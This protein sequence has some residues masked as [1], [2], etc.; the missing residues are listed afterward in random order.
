MEKLHVSSQLCC[1]ETGTGIQKETRMGAGMTICPNSR[2]G[3]NEE[4]TIK[5][6]YF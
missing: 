4:I 1:T 3:Y 2:Y 6:I 5:N